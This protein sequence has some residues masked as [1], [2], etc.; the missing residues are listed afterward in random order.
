[1]KRATLGFL[2]P[3]ALIATTIT[4]IAIAVLAFFSGGQMFTAGALNAKIGDNLG[5]VS[6]HAEIAGDC[7]KCHPAP[8]EADT[9]ND[10][11]KNCHTNVKAEL[12]D[13]TSLHGAMMYSNAL[14][15]RDCHTEHRGAAVSLTDMSMKKF[16]H[17]AT[18]YSLKSHAAR[19]DGVSFTCEDCHQS[20]ITSLDPSICS[21]CHQ[22]IDLAFMEKHNQDYGPECLGCHDGWETINKLFDHSKAAFKIEGKHI[23]VLCE[24]CHLNAHIAIDFKS[25]ST[26]CSN[27]HLKDDAHAGRFGTNCADCHKVDGWKPASFDHN[28]T[29]FKLEG[30][31]AGVECVTCHVNEVYKNT[32]AECFACHQKDDTHKGAFGEKCGVCHTIQGWKPASFDHNLAAF[33]LTGEHTNVKCET[34]HVNNVYKGTPT[35]C[36]GCHAKDDTHKGSLGQNCETCHVTKAWKPASFDHNLSAFK[37]TGTHANV[38]CQTCHVNNVFKGTPTACF[39]CHAKDDHHNGSLGQ[40]CE[41]CH[42]TTAWSPASFDHNLSAFKLTGTHANVACQTCHVNN[43]FKG[44]PTACFACHAK[45]DTHKGSMGQ[46]CQLCHSTT[47]WKPS[48]FNHNQAGFKLTGAHSSAA[49]TQC[50]VN[51]VFK[52]TPSTCF[53]CHANIDKH[54]GQMG[55]NC[56]VCHSTS[57]WKPASFDHNQADFK[58]TGTHVSVKCDT[59]HVNGVYKGTP[60]TCFGCHASKDTHNGSLGQNCQTCHST[61]AWKP[62]SFDHNTSI[63]KLTGAHV[64]AACTRCHVNNVFKGT[65]TNCYAC[66]VSDDTHKGSMGQSCQ[67]CHVTTAWKPA[68]FDHNTASFKLV[69]AHVSAACTRC[70]VNG[71]FKGT[72]STC[73]ACHASDDTHKGSMGQ[74]C[75]VCHSSTAWKPASFDHN[76]AAFKLTGAHVSAACSRCHVNGVYKGTPS[77][78]YA[79]HASKDTHK[80]ALGQICQ[81]CHGTTAWKP[82]TFDHNTSA[83]KLTG[84]HVSAACTR[85]HS[86]GVFKG[87]PSNCYACHISDDTHRG[88]MGQLCQTC[89]ATGAW[90]PST[91]NHNTASFK[92][93]GAHIS[94]ACSRCHVNGVFKGTPSTC[95]SC[96]ASDDIHKGSM[97]QNCGV[98]HT[99]TAWKP[100][101][102]DHNTAAFKL[103]GAHVS[104]ACS[105]CHVNGVYKGTPSNCYAC[106]A[107]K[108]T[109]KGALGQNCQ[110]CHATTAWKPSTFDHNT[111]AFKLTGAHVSAA[112]TRCHS[113]G[114]F[115]GTPSN[116]YACHVSDDTH[117]GSMGQ[118]CQTCH[119]TSAWKPSTFNH[120]TSS[121]KLVGAHVSAACSR[122]HVN[123]VFKGTPSTCYSCHVSDD[124]HKGSM[125]QNCGVCHTPTAWKPASF[126]HN[127]AA[128]KL[129]GAHVSAACSRCHVNGV[130]KGTPSNCYAC[131]VSKDTHK[132]SLGQL[133]QT[134]HTTTAWKPSTFDH[135]TSAF[136]LTGAHVSAACTRCHVNGVY[137]G[138]PSNCYA[139]HISDDTHRGSMGQLCQTCHTTTAW[140]P[141]TFDHN[142]SAFKLTGAHA[143]AACSR[144]HV[145]GVFKGTPSNCYAC[146][147]SKD[148]H[149]G[150]LGQTCQSCHTTSAWKP[151]TFDHNTS[152]F[153]LTGAHVNAACLRCHANNSS[154]KGTPSNC[155][156]CHVSDDTHKGSMGQSCQTCHSTSVWKPSTFDHNSAAFKLTGA[157]VSA[158]CTRCH[159]NAVFKGT[160]SNCYAC[161]VSKD[162]HKG[163]L[164]Q[165]CQTCH[166]TSAWKPTTF[167]HNSSAFKLTGAHVSAV[168][169]RCHANNSSYKGTPTTCYGCHA[170]KDAHTGTLGQLC[171]ACHSTNAWKPASFDHNSTAFKLTGAHVSAACTRCH[172]NNS[173]YKGTP[174]ACY[175]CHASKDSHNGNLGQSCASC[176]TTS[177]WKPTT[178]V[179]STSAFKLTG[180]HV[181]AACTRCHANNSS[182]RGTPST[183][184]ACHASKDAHSGTLGQSCGTCHS[185]NAW[186]PA[187]FDHNTTAFKLTGAHVN[188]ACTR[189]H[190]NNSSYKGTPSNCYACHASKDAH[191]GT[192]GQSCGTC[193]TTNV[194]KP[195]TF[196]H[197][198]SAFK[199]TGAHSSAACTR[200]HANNSSYKGTPSNCYACHASKDAH[201][202]TLGQSC[203]TCHSTSAWKPSSFD[204]SSSAFKLTGAHVSAACS[205]CHA[206]NSSYKGTPSTCYACH[207]SKDTHKG[208][209]GQ[210][211]STCHS[212]SAWKPSTFDHNSSAFKLM[213]AHGN[214]ACTSCHINGVFKGTPT[215]CI[216]CHA[217][218][219]HHAGAYGQNC[220]SCH[221]TSAW[222]PASFDHNLS[223]FKLTGAHTNAACTSCHANGVFKGTPQA[224]ASCHNN[225]AFHAGLFTGTACSSCHTTSAWRPATYTGP[226]TFPMKHGSK[227]NTCKT[228]HP[229]AL[230][231]YTC[232]SCHDQAKL[233]K[234]HKDEGITNFT[235]CMQCHPTGKNN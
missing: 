62:A 3:S 78:C 202:G 112:C 137:K 215:T 233:T 63:F 159:V 216:G 192:L 206:N 127:T 212:T 13:I 35:A 91:F 139:C 217:N 134:C 45:N 36:F 132:G 29:T 111:S 235:D 80:G 82:A 191:S 170:S 207:A 66:H 117:R 178:F 116:C 219:D 167:D 103:T 69:G 89:H 18:G 205:R 95:Y 177:A 220:A 232:F 61:Q 150:T 48:T 79:C 197:G 204:H 138:T 38:A 109:H 119:A 19:S 135:S 15:C 40:N 84:A 77:N 4:S 43:V 21:T 161:H 184:Y 88:S 227:N 46:S 214:V 148:T 174:T 168:C 42:T 49:C 115:K 27:C 144:C 153:K 114:V 143:S 186:K 223:A 52:G 10:R 226:H 190:A 110:T 208:T 169:T 6:S 165:T 201:S 25:L 118:L 113:N 55:Q 20:D 176:H 133:C 180:A 81:T 34:C 24:K 94:A 189:C 50:H 90:K 203:S 1:M 56:G 181:A 86:N 209:L 54:N 122:C 152:A 83:F 196:D 100:A 104:A 145:N 131:H 224:C 198:S 5:G 199:L 173:S 234:K 128:F 210:S 11:C 126:D 136:K 67:T 155:Y 8:W 26:E 53:G 166:T 123:G 74:N 102:F 58:L 154:Y 17:E 105:R 23:G 172:A 14:N 225:P 151:S 160:P 142:T 99:P 218:D 65:P 22:N 87:T 124:I 12:D 125:G 39:G 33:K 107:S 146:H 149:K 59:C 7:A 75:G 72:P 129:T 163:T 130:Y 68:T 140:K 96:H 222:K 30:K 195:S 156:A 85:C 187:S 16:P 188:A 47:A 101:A 211:C 228:C 164:G 221:S 92:L 194:W 57:A 37:L 32:S 193:H 183:C 9:I 2:T 60:S 76:T 98:C 93:V 141:S 97:G 171:G 31:H 51:A 157:H 121:F 182:Y 70:H 73:Y 108:D 162:T 229:S 28:L 185:T 44:T 230:T 175:G 41:T 158:V 213:G 64:S 120:N 231:A 179:H 147:A 106:H 71:V 200:C